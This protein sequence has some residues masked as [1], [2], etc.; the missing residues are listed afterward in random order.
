MLK[1]IIKV[2]FIILVVTLVNSCTSSNSNT[3]AEFYTQIHK[4]YYIDD[5]VLIII[6]YDGYLVL[7]RLNNEYWKVPEIGPSLDNC[8]VYKKL[9]IFPYR[10]E[11]L[12]Y[13]ALTGKLIWSTNIPDVSCLKPAVNNNYIQVLSDDG[14]YYNLDLNGEIIKKEPLNITDTYYIQQY[15]N[16][17]V[18]YTTNKKHDRVL[19]YKSFDNSVNWTFKVDEKYEY[20]SSLPGKPLLTK[21]YILFFSVLGTDGYWIF[22][23]KKT[24]NFVKEVESSVI[25]ALKV[26]ELNSGIIVSDDIYS[27]ITTLYDKDDVN[28]IKWDDEGLKSPRYFDK[29][30]M[31]YQYGSDNY[32]CLDINTGELLGYLHAKNI[33]DIYGDTVF[34][35]ETDY[36]MNYTKI[37]SRKFELS[38][39]PYK[40]KRIESL[41]LS[42]LY[43]IFE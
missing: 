17:G 12:A 27:G 1:K 25:R 10:E 28:K 34:E 21:N 40:S 18:L 8:L 2:A 39:T 19:Y 24:G 41:C 14:F 9:L 20:Y 23:D 30:K 43:W 3:I 35:Y 6:T 38:P 37:N 7:N 13:D 15:D 4:N 11:L 32:V 36:T 31:Y 16:R 5:E 22:L 29:D 33:I 42:L 26:A